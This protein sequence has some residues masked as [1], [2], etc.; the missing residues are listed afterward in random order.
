MSLIKSLQDKILGH[1]GRTE[2]IVTGNN[3]TRS[4]VTEDHVRT[5]LKEVRDPD[6]HEDIVTLG[7]VQNIS[8]KPPRLD[9]EVRLTTPACPVKE[10]L[11]QQCE[12]ALL[13]LPGITEVHVTMTAETRGKSVASDHPGAAALSEVKN[14]IAVASGKGGVGKSTTAVHLAFALAASGSKVGLLDA[15]IYGP[16]IPLMTRPE[17]SGKASTNSQLIEPLDAKGVK[18]MSIGFFNQGNKASI[19]RGPMAGGVIKQFLGQVHWGALDYLIIDYPPGTGDIQ[20]TISQTAPITGAVIVTTPQELA[21]IDVRKAMSMFETLK[22]PVLGVIETMSYF[23]CDHCD[24]RHHIFRQGGGQ[25]LAAENGLALLG[26][27]P[28]EPSLVE[29]GDQ[30]VTSLKAPTSPALQAYK[31]AAGALAAQVSILHAHQPEALKSFSL[32]WK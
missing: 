23:I 12:K 25:K 28:L 14:I 30:G 15:D 6:L 16:S 20:L 18:V 21:L 3:V 29:W 5:A 17:V 31:T 32:T 27:I 7:F 2:A 26:Q 24:K 10:Q 9:V 4:N 1:G 8:I 13:S 22:V 19:L 11:K